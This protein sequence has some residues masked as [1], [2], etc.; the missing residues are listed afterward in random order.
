MNNHFHL[1]HLAFAAL[2][3]SSFS[4]SAQDFVEG[5]VL[6]L[7]KSTLSS[8]SRSSARSALSA[9]SKRKTF[10]TLSRRSGKSIQYIK[11]PTRT[12]DELIALFQ[13]DPTVESVSA[14]YIKHVSA[15]PATPDDPA[16]ALQWAY[17]NTAQSAPIIPG[18]ADADIDLPEARRLMNTDPM[19]V[20][21]AIIDTGVDYTH[22]DL[23]DVMWTNSGEIPGNS[24][25]DD[26]NGFID[27][28]YGYDFAGDDYPH[29][30]GGTVND[31]PDSDPMDV[32]SHGTHVAGCAAAAVDNARGI[33]SPGT[34]QIMALK[35]SSDGEHI[36]D[37]ASIAAID[38]LLAMKAS[39]VNIVVANA[40]YGGT[41]FDEIENTAFG[42]LNSAG[43]VVTAAAGNSTNNNDSIPH[44]PSSFTHANILSV[45]ATDPDDE[46]SS[47]SNY[48]LTSVDVAAPG[49]DIYSTVPVHMGT[50]ALVTRNAQNYSAAGFAFAGTTEGIE[51]PFYDCGLGHSADFPTAVSGNIALI[52]RGGLYFSEKVENAM[53]AGAVAAIIYNKVGEAGLVYGTLGRPDD[54]IPAVGISRSDGIEL[55][56]LAGTTVT[57]IN[58]PDAANAYDYKSGTSMATPIAAGCI[59]VLAQHFPTETAQQLIAR[60]KNN[61]DPK[62]SLTGKCSTGGRINLAHCLDTDADQLPD[63]WELQYAANI[64]TMNSTSDLDNDGFPDLSEYRASSIPN[65]PQSQWKV[66]LVGPIGLGGMQLEWPSEN[67]VFYRVLASD[68]LTDPQFSPISDI[69]SPT[70]P[71]NEWIAPTPNNAPARF[72]KIELIW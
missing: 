67:G 4:L 54:W 48:G 72:Y 52:E 15:L 30:A 13:A 5:E 51:A 70:P 23:A 27:D 11:D 21:V 33:A 69:L 38:Y 12:T 45:A 14:N 43:V 41:D 66:D 61:V 47:F 65:Q 71:R 25:D 63:W 59:G 6:V 16:F 50:A 44:Y 32:G 49:T 2:L 9:N 40:S 53:T 22:L 24:I 34:L 39:G 26:A 57:V 31:G 42:L 3:A 29:P 68:T 62:A 56:P 17:D 20:V 64:G 46:L 10:S 35:A 58:R 55:K 1:R 19:P 36:T 60:I 8:K 18:T 28:I 37:S 7:Y